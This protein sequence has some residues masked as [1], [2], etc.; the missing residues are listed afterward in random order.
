MKLKE[1]CESLEQDI[2]K[3]Y[4]VGCTLEEAE[5]L[6]AKFLHGMLSATKELKNVSLDAKMRK[7]GTKALKAALYLD[8]VK[9]SDKKPSDTLLNNIVDA[10]GLV[11][12]E[13]QQQYEAEENKE[14]LERYFSI[15]K[16]A[17]I[18]YRGIGKGRFE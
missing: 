1:L 14:E 3:S 12:V 16:E 9:K 13:E 18:Y 17:H 15:F 7:S 8:K 2:K 6:S 4:E 10:S 11:Q 5:R